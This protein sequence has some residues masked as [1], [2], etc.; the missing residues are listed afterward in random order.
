LEYLPP[1]SPDYQPIEQVFSVIKSHFR[2]N[3]QSTYSSRSMYHEMYAV[4]DAATPEMT[5]GF[6]SHSGYL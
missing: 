1:Y 6:F 3:G 5:W 2:Q 4:C